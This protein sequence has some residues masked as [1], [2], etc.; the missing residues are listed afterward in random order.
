[1]TREEKR[2][3]RITKMERILNELTETNRALSDALDKACKIQA[4]V[5][6]L[7]RYYDSLD[8]Q[9]DLNDD[10]AGLLPPD[11]KRGVL[12]QDGAYNALTEYRALLTRMLEIIA[13]ELRHGTI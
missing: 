1:M 11:L 10:E 5:A 8:W 9:Q 2:I 13:S 4:D 7:S 6:K 3:I 12:S